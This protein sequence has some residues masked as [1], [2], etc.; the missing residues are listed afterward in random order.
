METQT[1]PH[2]TA[3]PTPVRHSLARAVARA[4]KRQAKAAQGASV[5]EEEEYLLALIAKE[6]VKNDKKCK[7]KVEKYCKELKDSK[8]EPRKIHKKLESFCKNG[9]AEKKCTELKTK[10]E[11][12]CTKFKTQLTEVIKKENSE[13][14]NNICKE[15]ERQCLFLEGACSTELKNDCNS[16]RNKCYQKKRDEVAE[17]ALLRALSD[18]LKDTKT[19]KGKIKDV[20]RTLG[21][22]SNELMQRCFDTDSLCTSLVKTAEE[23]CK[24]LKKEIE[25]VLKPNGELQ[26]KGHSLL[27]ECHF[28]GQ[29]CKSSDKPECEKLVNKAKEKKITYKKPNSDF[30]PTKTKT[31]IAEKIGLEELYKEAAAQGVLIGRVLEGDI[32]DLLVFLSGKK[33]F[34]ETQCKEVFTTKCDSIKYLAENI[35]KLCGNKTERENR[36]KEFDEEFKKKKNTLTAKLENSQFEDEIALWDG[37]PTFL[38]ENECTRLQSD[39]FYFGGQT[40]FEKRCNNVRL[41]CYKRGRDALANQALQD[42]LR[43][44]FHD[45]NDKW[46]ETLQKELVKVCMGLEGKSDELF[47]LCVQPIEGSYVL[48]SDLHIKTDLLQK[49]LNE[50]RDFPTKRDCRELQKK[51]NDLKQD[52]EELEWPCLTL[53]HHCNRLNITEQLEER[54]L[55]E[56][57]KD[58]D[59]L[60]SCLK[61]LKEQC[62]KWSRRGRTQ[63]AFTCVAQNITCK[64]LTESVGSKCTTLEARIEASDVINQ[65]NK[66]DKKETICSSWAPYC[67]KFISSCHNL[68]TAGGGKCEKLN[69]ECKSFIERKD[70][71]EKVVYEL[72][73]SLKTKQECQNTLDKYCTQWTNA[74]NKLKTLCTDTTNGKNNTEVRKKLCKKLVERVKSQCPE[75]QKKLAEANKELEKKASKYENIKKEAEDAMKKASLVLSKAK[76]EN[77]KSENE[78]VPSVPAAPSGKDTKPF[79]LIRRDATAKVTEDEAKAF[80]LVAQAFGLY[81]ELR[82]ECQ[83]L[84][85]GCGFKKEC[86]CENQCEKIENTCKKL[87]P[88]EVKPYKIETVTKNIT[89]TTTTT[90]TKTEGEG[91]TAECQSLQTTDTWV[92]KTSTHTS[93]STTTS[94]VTSR[95]T[96]TST[97]RC[98]PTKCTTGEE[99]EAGEVKPSEGLRMSGWSVMR[100]VLVAMMISFMI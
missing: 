81:V 100:G 69:E 57:V 91:K 5:Y 33:S 9:E 3:Q 45:R 76:A 14:T 72:K 77:N 84:L 83:D 67:S 2:T 15:N 95:I 46:P 78:V 38:T 13:L 60:D 94:T 18:D 6:D 54:F 31:T 86:S 23:K 43:G 82:E 79:K 44:N 4:V 34:S 61:N 97:R 63:F 96:L 8:L 62:H 55:E 27:K 37:L 58:L 22:E 66:D 99:D 26:K 10:V 53:K 40:S 50:K 39:C 71:E 88:L 32:V 49:N 65:A 21:Q 25:N 52:F 51:C 92:T 1:Q 56:K 64:I 85:K 47:V 41:G 30:D 11:E 48:L 90:T 20:C 73:G 59:K 24:F 16:L 87:K 75:L 28:Y 35:E 80:D 98:K 93:T 89:T 29:N 42:K 74:K 7:D 70:L 12:K 68:T 17:E 19:C 36:C